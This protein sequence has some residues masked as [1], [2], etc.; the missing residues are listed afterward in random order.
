MRSLS[1]R[2]TL[3]IA[4]CWACRACTICRRHALLRLISLAKSPDLCLFV[5]FCCRARTFIEPVTAFICDKLPNRMRETSRMD[6]LSVDIEKLPLHAIMDISVWLSNK[7]ASLIR[8]EV[9]GAGHAALQVACHH[10]TP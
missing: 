1:A 7:V 4:C 8:E 9:G 3:A 6:M 10:D 5:P 2:K